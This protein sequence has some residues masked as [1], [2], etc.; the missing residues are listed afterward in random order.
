MHASARPICSRPAPREVAVI[1]DVHGCADALR[2]LLD[3]IDVVAAGAKVVLVGDLLTTGQDPAGVVEV[4]SGG[5]GSRAGFEFD[6]VCGNHDLRMRAALRAISLG[7]PQE[8]LAPIERRC[9]T[10]L[11]S[12][13][14]AEVARVLLDRIA[15]Q[16][17][18]EVDGATVLHAGIDPARGRARTPAE[19]KWSIKARRGERPWWDRYHGDDGLLVFGHKP[20]EEPLRRRARGRVAAVNVDTGCADGGRLTAYLVGSDRFVSVAAEPER[21]VLSFTPA[22]AA[23]AASGR[24][25][26]SVARA[27]RPAHSA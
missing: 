18:L 5:W 3:R 14:R 8:N 11:Q 12:A 13:G 19:L 2:R 15:T 25:A 20:L 22:S 9:I 17:E 4:L 23:L 27:R 24:Q 7:T 1:G 26:A 10:R 6:S 21:L 16:V